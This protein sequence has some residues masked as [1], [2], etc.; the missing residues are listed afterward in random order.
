M[1][2]PAGTPIPQGGNQPFYNIINSQKRQYQASGIAA[3]GLGQKG[4]Q[5]MPCAYRKAGSKEC[6]EA[7]EQVLPKPDMHPPDS[8]ADAYQQGIKACGHSEQ[9]RR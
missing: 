6:H 7:D 3:D 8:V 9:E 5:Q 1:R 2:K 4:N